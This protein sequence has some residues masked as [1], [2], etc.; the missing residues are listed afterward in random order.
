V[1]YFKWRLDVSDK[2]Q[3]EYEGRKNMD[4]WRMKKIVWMLL[5]ALLLAG[6]QEKP[7]EQM[8]E[9]LPE[10]TQ[11][12]TDSEQIVETNASVPEEN[13]E[14]VSAE[15]REVVTA[16]IVDTIDAENLKQYTRYKL[17][18]IPLITDSI[19]SE[20]FG[21]DALDTVNTYAGMPIVKAPQSGGCL[22]LRNW[23]TSDLSAYR[24]NG[25]ISFM[26]KSEGAK[27]ITIGLQDHV[28]E[29][30]KQEITSAITV[31]DLSTEW[32]Q[33]SIPLEDFFTQMPELD[34]EYLWT[35]RVN[36]DGKAYLANMIIS[37]EA[38][39]TVYPTIKVNQIGYRPGGEKKALV[40][41]FREILLCDNATEFQLI[42]T[43]TQEIVYAGT[44]SLVDDYDEHSGEAVYVMDFSEWKEEG[45]YRVIFM[46]YNKVTY[47]SV[48]FV[49]GETV[50]EQLLSDVCR[51]YYFQRA[52]VAL[53][54]KYAG[55]WAREG[56][57]MEDY[58]MAFLSDNTKKK[59]VSGGWF[60]AG[61]FGKY[62]DPGA[63][64]VYDL[65][66]AYHFFPE[67]FTDGQNNIPESGNG[68]PDLLDEIK[69]E[70]DFMLKMQDE[71]G[72]FFHRVKPDDSSRRIVDTFGSAGEREKA[73]SATAS[74]AA[75]MAFGS[76]YYK[77]FDT[78]FADVLLSSAENGWKYVKENPSVISTG[79]Y[80]TA[81]LTSQKLWAACCLYYA[82]G[83]EEYHDYIKNHVEDFS[84]G[85]DIYSYGHGTERMQKLAYF[86]YLLSEE[87]SAKVTDLIRPKYET[88]RK[89]MV[90]CINRNPWGTALET[91]AYWWG[92]NGNALAVAMEMYIGDRL[93][94]GN[95][96][97]A[98]SYAQGTFDYILGKNPLAM[99]YVTGE[100]TRSISCAYSGI[101]S[102]DGLEG[103]PPGYMPG[104]VNSYDNW[105][106]SAYPAKCYD[107][108][109]F[110]WVSNENAIYYN[111]PLV[112]VTALCNS[113]YK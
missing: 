15:K 81:E 64:A 38:P 112:F 12:Q 43:D 44:L 109:S 82:T 88:W 78:E 95:T 54:R 17:K 63:T 59:D 7:Q 10:Q 16:D 75:V 53:E 20:S 41:G 57:F 65:L 101:F 42:T 22:V 61:D 86:T 72:G 73:T 29:R 24:A 98:V 52:N 45:E 77:E 99:S 60:D 103:F 4:K 85:F 62:V 83:K 105:I 46:D 39:E 100:G 90:G 47:G 13:T 91:W 40:S 11:E 18:D 56:L 113:E 69:V 25:V 2:S 84:A 94:G 19:A 89:A 97:E 21:F 87:T 111:S 71:D 6:C 27:T 26:I 76:V 80:G 32:M 28:M 67:D 68:I 107:D 96:Q 36:T 106:M 55:E 48:P 23:N 14:V 1:L 31:E 93:T 92:S 33:V 30:K 5:W 49:I 35:I 8:Q 37:S 3:I 50:Y 70:L 104:G 34:E 58:N 51:Y 102:A 74:C 9:Q 79:T 66:W 110:D 108:S